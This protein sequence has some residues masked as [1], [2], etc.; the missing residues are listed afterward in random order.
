MKKAFP[1]ILLAL[2]AIGA[3]LIKR[4]R[5]GHTAASQVD[6]NKVFDR[7]TGFLEY[8]EHA[9]CRMACAHITEQQVVRVLD[10]GTVSNMRSELN[11]K[12]CPVYIVEGYTAEKTRLRVAFAQCDAKTKVMSCNYVDSTIDCSCKGVGSKYDKE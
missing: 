10:S 7:R 9:K 3:L 4:C 6:R 5:N 1:Y 12:P 8:T 11:A 2:L